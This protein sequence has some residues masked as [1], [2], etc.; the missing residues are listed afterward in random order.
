MPTQ[1]KKEGFQ[2]QKAIVIP[3]KILANQCV[4]NPIIHSLYITDIGYYPKAEYHYRERPHG[5][6]QHILIHCFEGSGIVKIN[7]V[8]YNIATG[9]FFFVPMKTAHFYCADEN[10][11]WTIYWI[12]FKGQTADSIVSLMKK[13]N[14]GFKGY[15]KYA[16]KTISFFKE[17]YSQMERGYSR[18]NLTYANM[19]LW[20]YLTTFLYNDKSLPEGSKISNKDEIDRAIDYLS[21][22]IDHILTLD[23]IASSVNLSASHFSYLFKRKTGFSV[24][25]Y[26]NHLKV[27][28]ACQ[29]ILFT[30]MRIGEI[31]LEVGIGDQYYFSRM[32]TKIMGI[33]PNEYRKKRI[34]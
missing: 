2:G 34:H 11:P 22:H 9:D 5:A 1:K 23:E 27:Q 25:E 28:K 33:S 31:A 7:K 10:N 18:D 24:I 12:H 3:R 15:L 6:D 20:H 14:N 32:F 13:Q 16:E 19:C 26:F 21:E 4:K 8:S 30:N 17:I 29:Y